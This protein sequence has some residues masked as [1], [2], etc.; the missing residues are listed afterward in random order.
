MTHISD[1]YVSEAAIGEA[2]G[3]PRQEK[4]ESPISRFLNSGWGVAIICTFVS[5][6]VVVALVRWGQAGSPV[7]PAGVPVDSDTEPAPISNRFEFSYE[8]PN[9]EGNPQATATYFPGDTFTVNATV[10]NQGGAFFYTGSSS[11]YCPDVRFVLRGEEDVSV[12]HGGIVHTTD[13]GTFLVKKGE[14]GHGCYTFE[15]PTNATPGVYD[16]ILSYK[17]VEQIF[18]GVLT[19]EAEK[20]TLDILQF[21]FGYAPIQNATVALG[22]RFT[23]DTWVKNEGAAFTFKGSSSGFVPKSILRHSESDYTIIGLYDLPTDY[24]T[25]TVHPGEIGT[26]SPEFYIPADEPEGVYDLIL[27][28]K[29]VEKTFTGVLT[30]EVYEVETDIIQF[31]FGYQPNVSNTTLPLDFLCLDVWVKNEGA[32]FTFEGSSSGFVPQSALR[33]QKSGYTITGEF[34]LPTDYGTVTVQSGE[35]GTCSPV[36][37]I[38]PDI[39]MG[40]YDLVVS[41]T[42]D[43]QTFEQVFTDV[44]ALA[45]DEPSPSDEF[46]TLD[47]TTEALLCDACA[48]ANPYANSADISV[49]HYYGT[50]DTGAIVAMMNDGSYVTQAFWS[51]QVGPADIRYWNGQ[52]ILVLYD[53]AFLTLQEAFDQG[54]L[55]DEDLATIENIHRRYAPYLYSDPDE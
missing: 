21:S 47:P 6:F 29:A 7:G 53:K 38:T 28:Y 9:E 46:P 50:Y 13:V 23:M 31:S 22:D 24:G 37:H 19:V 33:H 16:L 25:V 18:T 48:A 54:A 8:I 51:E 20:T 42:L 40:V 41:Y 32:A 4:A 49:R 15:I 12:L 27:S 10:T 17:D 39:P 3:N 45:G 43:G 35:V 5:L 11:E 36:F 44:Y 14:I 52:Q 34:D 1:E 30:V 26:C 55:T 2:Y